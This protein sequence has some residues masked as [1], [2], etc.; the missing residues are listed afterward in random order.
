[1][2]RR[3]SR[4]R[5]PIG[6]HVG[7]R[8][9]RGGGSVSGGVAQSVEQ[10]AHNR[11]VVGSSPA[12]ATAGV[13]RPRGRSR[14]EHRAGR[15]LLVPS[16][17]AGLTDA[18][19][20]RRLHRGQQD[21]GRPPEDHAGVHGVQG[22]QLHHQEEPA[23]RPRP[24]RAEE[25][26]PRLRHA[27][28]A[29]R[30][31]LTFAVARPHHPRPLSRERPRR[32]SWGAL[33]PADRSARRKD[34]MGVNPD[35]AGRE[36]PPTPVLRGRPRE[37]PRVRRRDRQRRPARTATRRPRAR[38]GHP[39]VIAPPTFAVIVAQRAE[40]QS[41]Q[42][43][44]GRHRLLAAWCT[45]RR[46]SPTTGPSSRATAW[47]ATLHV[48]GVREAGGHGMVTTRVEIA[49]EGGEPVATAVSTIVVR[50]GRVTWRRP[51]F[52]AVAV[53]DDAAVADLPARP[54][55][56]LV[57]YAGASGDFNAIHWNERIAAVG[58]PA[59]RHRARHAHHGHGRAA[60]HRLGGRPGRRASST[61]SGSPSRSSCRTTTRAPG[62]RCPAW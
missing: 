44:R 52:D 40:A 20:E 15:P 14:P 41:S 55:L 25:V 51:A 24:A 26:L 49:T 54:A 1:M 34:P 50:G 29:P 62:S 2:V 46:G 13:D 6:A 11:C 10:A 37:D 7:P 4:V 36:Y 33:E 27:H 21:A 31:P 42:D 3:R 57:R 18:S 47:S 12:S 61:G 17:L 19:T 48:D 59:R 38:S 32:S 8:P 60:R 53:G 56:D 30:D 58:R 39:D 9:M 43:P 28:R 35:I 23:Q 5:F 45:A 22:A 16:P